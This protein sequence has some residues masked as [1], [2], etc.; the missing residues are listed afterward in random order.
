MIEVFNKDNKVNIKSINNV[1]ITLDIDKKEVSIGD[2]LIDFP[3]EYEKSWILLEV[4]E[5]EQKMFYSFLVEQ[6]IIFV[7]FEDEFDISKQEILSFFWD[8]DILLIVWTKNAAKI[9]ENIEARVVIPFW[10]SKDIFL[11]TLWQHK[12][13]IDN[14]KLKVEMWVENT[15][16]INLKQ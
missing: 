3:W 2:Y 8:V 5:Y 16:F 14:F 12:E 15:E 13:E 10:E 11:N 1:L 4:K 7:L 9:S 6:K